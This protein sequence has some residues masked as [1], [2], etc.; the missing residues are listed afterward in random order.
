MKK[1]ERKEEII[2]EVSD[3][4]WDNDTILSQAE[5]KKVIKTLEKHL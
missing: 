4:L 5:I 1:N 2:N 3:K